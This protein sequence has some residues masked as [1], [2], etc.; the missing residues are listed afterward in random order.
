MG[1]KQ[2]VKHGYL[3][4][5]QKCMCPHAIERRN[6]QK[7]LIPRQKKLAVSRIAHQPVLQ[8]GNAAQVRWPIFQFVCYQ[9]P[10]MCFSAERWPQNR[11]FKYDRTEKNLFTISD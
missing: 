8:F 11:C 2:L 10:F 6:S 9:K 3:V 7:G 5:R 1:T 4:S